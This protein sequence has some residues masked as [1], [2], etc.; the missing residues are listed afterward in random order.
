M[1][2]SAIQFPQSGVASETIR[3]VVSGQDI[4]TLLLGNGNPSDN[5]IINGG[6]DFW[7]RGLTGIP[8]NVPKGGYASADRWKIWGHQYGLGINYGTLTRSTDTPTLNSEYSG[9]VA[10]TAAGT[11]D[12]TLVQYIESGTARNLVGK[13]CTFSFYFKRL[14]ATLPAASFLRVEAGTLDAKDVGVD[15]AFNS[16]PVGGTIITKSTHASATLSTAWT[17]YSITFTVPSSG[18]N[19]LYLTVQ[20]GNDGADGIN[21]GVGNIFAIGEA[22]LNIGPTAMPFQRA[23]KHIG[24]ELALCQRYCEVLMSAGIDYSYPISMN[25]ATKGEYSAVFKQAKRVAPTLQRT[26]SD[27]DF[28]RIVQYSSSF[29]VTT[30]RITAVELYNGGTDTHSAV[31]NFTASY[32][33]ASVATTADAFGLTSN[34]LYFDAEI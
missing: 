31:V 8:V 25:S 29:V 17:K 23:G 34:I 14:A 24:G 13:Q 7:Q 28:G 4:R 22:M 2:S 3:G 32:V 33:G 5:F 30:S 12:V 11:D 19:G 20:L 21:L 10:S 9:V 6:F 1:S 15:Y 27:S 26:G 18:V 16:D